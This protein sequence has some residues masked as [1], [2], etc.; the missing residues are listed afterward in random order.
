MLGRS[1]KVVD[2]DWTEIRRHDDSIKPI[3]AAPRLWAARN[4]ER[5]GKVG[6]RLVSESD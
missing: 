6:D 2:A 4:L 1:G 3:G 5:A